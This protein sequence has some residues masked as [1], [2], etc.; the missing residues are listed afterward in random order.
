MLCTKL[1]SR[2]FSFMQVRVFSLDERYNCLRTLDLNKYFAQHQ[3]E[4]EDDVELQDEP[5]LAVLGL[6]Y[7]CH[8]K[9][10]ETL[11]DDYHATRYINT[12]VL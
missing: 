5:G 2:V 6:C 12:L 1:R 3:Q 8:R 10:E 11:R 4:K 7:N 9:N